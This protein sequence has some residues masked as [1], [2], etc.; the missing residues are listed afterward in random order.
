MLNNLG[1]LIIKVWGSKNFILRQPLKIWKDDVWV[2]NWCKIEPKLA[3]EDLTLYFYFTRTSL[4][5]KVKYMSSKLS[6]FGNSKM[7]FLAIKSTIS[8]HPFFYFINEFVIR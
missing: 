5:E 2:Q 6:V 7:Q 8:Q 3:N 1:F 4:D